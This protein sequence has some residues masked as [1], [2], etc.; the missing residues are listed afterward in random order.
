MGFYSKRVKSLAELKPGARLGIQ[1]EPSNSG[2]ALQRL[3]N[4]GLI[5][6]QPTA[7]IGATVANMIENPKPLQI[8]QVEAAQLPHSFDDVDAAAIDTHC[9]SRR[10]EQALGAEAVQGVPVAQSEDAGRG[11]VQRRAGAGVLMGGSMRRA[12]RSWKRPF[13]RPSTRPSTCPSMR[14]SK[15]RGAAPR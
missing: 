13:T 3:A 10:R 1:N 8:I 6:L 4:V 11:R 2:R 14:Q 15:R 7:G 5:K 9:A 12:R